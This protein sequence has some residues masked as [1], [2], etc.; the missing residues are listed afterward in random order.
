M[1]LDDGWTGRI[2]D[3][4][5][6]V[7]A[8][9]GKG[10]M[11]LV[12]KARHKFT[13]A[14]VALKVLRPEL[15][16]DPDVQM[17]FLGEARAPSVI[18]HPGIVQVVDAGTAPDGLLYLVMELLTGRPLRIPMARGELTHPDIRRIMM[19]LFDALAAAHVRGFVHRDLKPE[20]VFLEGPSATVKLLDFG[21]A[22]V[23]DAGL[24]RVRTAT[25]VT[26]GTPA[27][28]APEQFNDPSGVD[29]RADL[30]AAGVMIYEM[31]CGRLPFEG[32]T[33]GA[34]LVAV[35]TKDPTSIRAY[36]PAAPP[37]IEAFL[38]RALSRD[39]FRR[40]ASA[41]EMAQAFAAL[42]LGWAPGAASVVAGGGATVA[43]GVVFLPH[44]G[45]SAAMGA[46]AAQTPMPIAAYAP[47]PAAQS[48]QTPMPGAAYAPH[49]A[50][51]SVQTPMPISAY[52]PH[53]AGHLGKTMR[54]GA[55]TPGPIAVLPPGGPPPDATM[56]VPRAARSPVGIILGVIGVV[57][58]IAAVLVVSTS[59]RDTKGVS[60][61]GSA[62]PGAAA[63]IA[64]APPVDAAVVAP[65]RDAGA[66][67]PPRDAATAKTVPKDA[68]AIV[69][70][71]TDKEICEAGCTAAVKCGLAARSCVADCLRDANVR[72]CTNLARKGSCAATADCGLR[73]ACKGVVPRGQ[74]RC[75]TAASCV[76]ECALGDFACGCQCGVSMD[77]SDTLVFAQFVTC[78]INCGF[79]D[80]CM[81]TRCKPRI[82]ACAKT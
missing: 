20:N 16:L 50:A 75:S 55:E 2:I 54:P 38:T 71:E 13:G 69:S 60:S 40:F 46:N 61:Q 43:T 3:G 66:V 8:V 31:L 35:A 51:Q 52:T 78:G 28:M 80:D 32:A 11:G 56:P 73:L 10:G 24:A 25:G 9:I 70:I 36:L 21:I 64:V 26:L 27:Y 53:P 65:A 44:P 22:K 67:G 33:T 23:L 49:P 19:E 5:Y 79:E 39:L 12:L 58:L 29:A 82:V 77:P 1:V 15:E 72:K 14:D 62:L 68:G 34:F 17:R 4:R 30:W 48:V 63:V 45:G 81:A 6:V 59:R 76:L 37:T 41:Q 18:G 47:H 74:G 57:A 7:E 42:P